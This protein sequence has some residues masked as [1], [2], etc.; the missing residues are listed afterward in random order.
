M[1]SWFKH[2]SNPKEVQA[3]PEPAD[4][5]LLH[6]HDMAKWNYL[7]YTCCTYADGSG[8][9]LS[10]HPIFLFVDKNNDKR[11]SYFVTSENVEKTH[12][13]INKSVKPW[14]IGEGEIYYLITGEGNYPGDYLKEYMLDKFS[15][16]WD[17]DTNWWGTC[18]EAKYNS[19]QDKQKRESKTKSKTETKYDNNVVT[20]EFGKQA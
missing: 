18:D 13:Y 20:V 10:E 12:P 7:G 3:L 2:K 6:N 5:V 9:Q 4:L 1:F 15:A 17:N 16:E 8:K 11:R 19:A 14:A